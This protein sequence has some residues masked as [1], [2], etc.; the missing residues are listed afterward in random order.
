MSQGPSAPM[1]RGSVLTGARSG[2]IQM[3]SGRPVFDWAGKWAGGRVSLI[4]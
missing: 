3:A 2:W 1:L 4:L